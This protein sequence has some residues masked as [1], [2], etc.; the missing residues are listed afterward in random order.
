MRGRGPRRQLL[1]LH[2]C[3]GSLRQCL[4]CVCVLCK[5]IVYSVVSVGRYKLE[6][7]GGERERA[8]ERMADLSIFLEAE[9][10][11]NHSLV[12]SSHY[13]F[14]TVL[15][16]SSICSADD[17]ISTSR[18]Q[19]HRRRILPDLPRPTPNLWAWVGR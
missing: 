11:I 2:A 10:S 7:R 1:Y 16:G 9:N 17:L 12:T 3:L 19:V 14:L 18:F 6:S 8:R 5:L 13:Y 15:L 4:A